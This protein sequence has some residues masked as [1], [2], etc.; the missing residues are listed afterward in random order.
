LPKDLPNRLGCQQRLPQRIAR[1]ERL[2]K[3]Q[4]QLFSAGA[5]PLGLGGALQSPIQLPRGR[6][7]APRDDW[8]VGNLRC[9]S[10]EFF[11]SFEGSPGH[12]DAGGSLAREAMDNTVT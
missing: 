10:H 4:D 7:R 2:R 12:R 3:L 1:V 5:L 6:V 8:R 11:S 9:L